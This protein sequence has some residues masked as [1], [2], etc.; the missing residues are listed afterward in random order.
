LA[1]VLESTGLLAKESIDVLLDPLRMTE[2]EI[3]EKPKKR[4]N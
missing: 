2:P 1:E 3:S 4:K